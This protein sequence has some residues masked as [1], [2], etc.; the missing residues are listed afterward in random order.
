MMY[1]ITWDFSIIPEIK[2]TQK[3]TAFQKGR[4]R[5]LLALGND[6]HLCPP[7]VVLGV[8]NVLDKISERTTQ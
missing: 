5:P 4:I 3:I 2:H 7:W 1:C 8:G 6:A